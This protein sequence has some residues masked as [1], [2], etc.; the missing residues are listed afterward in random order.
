[1]DI[2]ERRQ[3]VALFRYSLIRPLAAPDLSAAERGALVRALVSGDHVGPDGRRVEVSAPTLRRWLRAWRGGGFSA[4]VPV[5]RAQ[6]TRTAAEI[7]DRAEV[8]KRE[9]PGR[10]AAQVARALA[11]AGVGVVSARSL[12]RH[13][14]RLGLNRSPDGAAA[15]VFGRFEAEQ[16]G[17]LW[18]GDGLHGPVVGGTK[19][20]LC[21]FI[22]DWS[23]A[24]PGWRWGRGEDTV[25][26]EAAL[27]RGLESR[28]IPEKCFVDNGSAF[29]SAPFNR[30]LAVLG[31]AIA[32]SRPR[33]PASRGKI[34]RF[35]A[36][37]RMQFLVEVDAR[38][39]VASLSELNELFGAWLEG[40]YHRAL[41]TETGET[42]L[43]RL[44]RARQLRRPSPAE[45]HEAFLWSQ[46]R[47]ADKT[48]GVSLFGNHYE[49]DA[50][51]AQVKVELVFDPFD[52]SDIDV[53]YQ[54]RPMGK[55]IPRR[56]T[57]HPPPPARPE[58]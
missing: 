20:V 11:E 2:D 10:S 16:F 26:L 14:A 17:A 18:T 39:G 22:D 29:I 41:H 55:A 43:A 37:V 3:A 51:L 19:A 47:T 36:T 5:V 25:R 1:M 46:T 35:F 23:R 49:L 53:R 12:Q 52:L 58:A 48:G 56:I 15:K 34:E 32:H 42:P 6:P 31:I 9:A 28:G 57:R 8:L 40:V 4:L 50:A 7:L 38:G 54:G 30:T 33:Q 13:F 21:A 44:M 27:R 45:L 24:V